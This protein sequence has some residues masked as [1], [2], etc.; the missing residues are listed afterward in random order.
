MDSEAGVP[1]R[2]RDQGNPNFSRF[3]CTDG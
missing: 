2:T 3:T 1:R